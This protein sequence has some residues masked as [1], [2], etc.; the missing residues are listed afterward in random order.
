MGFNKSELPVNDT[1]ES[2]KLK[3][4]L[5]DFSLCS[6]VLDKGKDAVAIV[7]LFLCLLTVPDITIAL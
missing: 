5:Q 2:G 6:S 3:V 4:P 7:N 1:R